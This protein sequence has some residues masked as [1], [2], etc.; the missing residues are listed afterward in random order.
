[1]TTATSTRVRCVVCQETIRGSYYTN[2]WNLPFHRRHGICI[3]CSYPTA[4]VGVHALCRSCRPTVVNQ[5]ADAT[6][7]ARAVCKR[8]EQRGIVIGSHPIRYG[9]ARVPNPGHNSLGIARATWSRAASGISSCQIDIV[10]RRGLPALQFDAVVAHELTHAWLRIH[11]VTPSDVIEEGIAE[12]T[13][14]WFLGRVGGSR[15]AALQHR[16]ATNNDH[17]YG[18][19]FRMA[20]KAE[21]RHGWPRVADALFRSG[22]LPG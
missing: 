15:A 6:A 7:R 21:Q 14:F 5:P 3:A 12:L 9:L 18:R 10:I 8:L 2:L 4:E 16:I 11:D 20:M 1:M 13:A 17:T 19:G 22:C